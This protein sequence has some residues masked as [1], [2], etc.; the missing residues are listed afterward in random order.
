MVMKKIIHSINF[1]RLKRMVI[2][3]ARLDAKIKTL[4]D[5]VEQQEKTLCP[6]LN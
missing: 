4:A 2:R 5:K 6:T 1:W 3:S